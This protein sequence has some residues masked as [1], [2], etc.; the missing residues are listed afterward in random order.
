[1]SSRSQR[2]L[3]SRTA[4]SNA[5]T[6]LYLNNPDPTSDDEDSNEENDIAIVDVANNQTDE[7]YDESTTVPIDTATDDE[8][9]DED[10]GF[11]VDPSSDEEDDLIESNVE[12]NIFIS[13]NGKEWSTETERIGRRPARNVFDGSQGYKRGL[14]PNSRK[15][16]FT[17]IFDLII[18]MTVQYTVQI[19]SEEGM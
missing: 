6:L 10:I 13:R 1:M 11:H 17:V 9:V 4:R 12:G 3:P 19:Y 16:S 5:N 2:I 15:E 18:D 7:I 14:R 8:V